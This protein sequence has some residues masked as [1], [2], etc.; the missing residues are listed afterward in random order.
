MNTASPVPKISNAAIA[1]IGLHFLG[2]FKKAYQRRKAVKEAWKQ[3]AALV[4]A[5]GKGRKVPKWTLPEKNELLSTGKVKGYDG[6]HINNVASAPHLAG[7]PNNIQFL[8]RPE[9]LAAHGG[10]WQNPTTGALIDRSF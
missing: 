2:K 1:K 6:H 4:K 8:T 7:D 9:H 3:E 5:T 10:S